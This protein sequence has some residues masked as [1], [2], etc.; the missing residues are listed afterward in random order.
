[1]M[2]TDKPLRILVTGASRGIGNVVANRLSKHHTV[3]G[4]SRTA[5]E[6]T[7]NFSF[8]QADVNS[9]ES[10]D[11]AF[12]QIGPVDVLINNAGV[13]AFGDF[14]SMSMEVMEEQ[15]QTNLVGSMR[16]MKTWLPPMIAASR[17]MIIT[18]NSVAATTTF[19]GCGAYA[20]SKAGLLA[21]TRSL[22]QDVRAHGIKVADLIVGATNTDIWDE[23]MRAEHAHRMMRPEDIATAITTLIDSFADS[24]S[25]IE[26]MTIRPQFGDL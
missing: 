23:S 13:A 25:M 21:L 1:M 8:T 17:G 26:E 16:L 11:R 20:A 14:Q 10:I 22:R 3:F 12:A 15:I 2:M 7:G 6:T 19:G 4:L 5:S 18:V 24:C 9:A